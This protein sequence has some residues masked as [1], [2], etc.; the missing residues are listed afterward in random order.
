[1]KCI[2]LLS[3]VDQALS[4]KWFSEDGTM[5][6]EQPVFLRANEEYQLARYGN[7]SYYEILQRVD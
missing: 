7:A 2:V 4:V 5:M 1:M 6:A 3:Q